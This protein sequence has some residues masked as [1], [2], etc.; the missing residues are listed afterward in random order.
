MDYL[1]GAGIFNAASNLS[2]WKWVNQT[3]YNATITTVNTVSYLSLTKSNTSSPN[4]DDGLYYYFGD[5]KPEHIHVEINVASSSKEAGDIRLVKISPTGNFTKESEKDS[6]FFRFGFYNYMRLNL[7][8]MVNKFD[9]DVWYTLDFILNWDRQAIALYVNNTFI[10]NEEFYY[11][12]RIDG[13]NAIILYNLAP[14]TTTKIAN[15]EV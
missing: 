11:T 3:G 4:F 6:V 2:S 5:Q 9:A 13:A 14:G 7:A 12:G 15:L 1:K 8:D 10:A